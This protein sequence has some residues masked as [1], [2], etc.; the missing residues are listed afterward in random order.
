M[1]PE[2]ILVTFLDIILRQKQ[3]KTANN[4]MCYV[5]KTHLTLQRKRNTF[6]CCMWNIR[7]KGCKTRTVEIFFFS[8][9]RKHIFLFSLFSMRKLAECIITRVKKVSASLRYR[10]CDCSYVQ[11]RIYYQN[12]ENIL[13]KSFTRV[14]VT[15]WSTGLTV[16]VVLIK[17]LVVNIKQQVRKATACK[18]KKFCHNKAARFF[19]FISV[20]LSFIALFAFH[21]SCSFQAARF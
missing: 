16:I 10:K 11:L 1:T 20:F 15:L 9:N 13:Q 5:I 12:P 3:K 7:R 8:G 2:G 21:L 14:I 6:L 17:S 19:T 18:T 4:C